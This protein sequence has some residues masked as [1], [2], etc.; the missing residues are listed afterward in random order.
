MVWIDLYQNDLL[1]HQLWTGHPQLDDMRSEQE[2]GISKASLGLLQ[3]SICTNRTVIKREIRSL[4]YR[5]MLPVAIDP[6]SMS[7]TNALKG[8]IVPITS[9]VA[10]VAPFVSLL[11]IILAL[12]VVSLSCCKS[13]WCMKC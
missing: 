11:L 12:I 4:H 7:S 5:L 8:Y 10:P 9:P 13:P 2:Y 6:A 1:R 3:Y